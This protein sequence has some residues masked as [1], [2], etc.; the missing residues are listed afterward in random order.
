MFKLMNHEDKLSFCRAIQLIRNIRVIY[1]D[2]CI[3]IKPDSVIREQ[4][5]KEIDLFSFER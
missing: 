5:F 1:I 4:L 2:L 3:G